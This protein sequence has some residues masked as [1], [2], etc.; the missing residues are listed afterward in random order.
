MAMS[1]LFR[2]SAM[3]TGELIKENAFDKRKHI[4]DP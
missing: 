2:A 4:R 1:P 3:C